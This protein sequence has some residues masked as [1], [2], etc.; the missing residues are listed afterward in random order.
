MPRNS[1]TQK[2]CFR[3][4]CKEKWA[5]KTIQSHF[6]G[7]DS[8]TEKH[9]AKNP[10]KQGVNEA[11]KYGRRWIQIAGPKLTPNQLHCATVPA[12][13]DCKWQEGAFERIEAKNKAALEAHFKAEIEAKD[14]FTN[15][16]WTE[17]ISPDGVKCFVVCT[18]SGKGP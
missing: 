14:Y 10:I 8:Q 5:Q 16:E 3:A 6:L 17:V 13:P 9:P 11:D 18:D 2:V 15:T 1:E 4:E 12:G 7:I